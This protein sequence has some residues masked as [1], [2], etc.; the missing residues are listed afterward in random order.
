MSADITWTLAGIDTRRWNVQAGSLWRPP[1]AVR[2]SVLTVPGRHGVVRTPRPPVFEEPIVSLEMRCKGAMSS[3]EA[4]YN[5]LQSLLTAPGLVLGRSSGGVTT[6]A[7]VEFVT[8]SPGQFLADVLADMSVQLA[9]PGVFFRAA[10]VD[11][12]AEIVTTG[13][14]VSLPGLA[15]GTGPVGD[16]A[17]RIRGAATSVSVVDVVSA[18]GISWTGALLGTEYLYLHPASA[19]ARRSTSA[20]AWTTGGDDVSGGL[21]YPAPG[22]LQIWPRMAAA[23]P[24]VRSARVTVTGAG[25]DATTALTVRAQPA[26]L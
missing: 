17:L 9:V 14:A 21:S 12:T 25:F 2:R 24:A 19:T 15:V 23:D 6:S 1:V 11:S 4:V 5:E 16:A 26:Y 3:L 13:E 8:A 22:L 10:S 7:P 20:T 18:T